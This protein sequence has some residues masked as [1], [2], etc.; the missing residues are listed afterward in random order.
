MKALRF[1]SVKHFNRGI[2][3]WILHK[4]FKCVSQILLYVN[5]SHYWWLMLCLDIL[6]EI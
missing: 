6:G 3:D 5:N 2:S 1:K 4:R